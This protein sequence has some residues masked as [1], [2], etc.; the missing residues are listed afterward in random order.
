MQAG[1]T[2]FTGWKRPVG[3]P[4]RA[5]SG[6]LRVACPCHHGSP[7]VRALLKDFLARYPD[8]RVEIE[9]YSSGWDQEPREEV[10]VFF[11][12][13]A[14]R[15]SIR[16][17]RPSP[18]TSGDFSRARITLRP[19][20]PPPPLMNSHRLPAW[21]GSLEVE[22]GREDRYT[23][24]SVQSCQADPVVHLDLALNG[25]GIVSCRSHGETPGHAR[26]AIADPPLWN[27]EPITLCALFFGG[28]ADAPKLVLL[29]F[30]GEYM[31]TDRDP[32]LHSVP[33]KGLF[34][35]PK[36]EA[37]SGP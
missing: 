28:A 21:L 17:V 19:A 16:R 4:A 22:P 24:H 8:L 9:P 29:D 25:L 3:E 23:Q 27:A 14:L 37:T 30:L 2:S 6:L 31:G 12:V 18:G 15:D 7:G 32:R 35:Y 11:K 20:A 10:D 34:T 13:R 5:A 26:S 33:A 1:A 36:L